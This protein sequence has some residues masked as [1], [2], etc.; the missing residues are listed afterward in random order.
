M[1]VHCGLLT[2][3][4][5]SVPRSIL[6]FG[7]AEGLRF[8]ASPLIGMA[9]TTQIDESPVL[10]SSAEALKLVATIFVCTVSDLPLPP[11][12]KTRPRDMAKA[13]S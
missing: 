11:I 2:K 9:E 12:L 6:P 4:S 13:A 1:L 8:G 7:A 5:Q 10:N 3:V